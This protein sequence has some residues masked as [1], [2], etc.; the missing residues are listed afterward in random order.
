[1]RIVGTIERCRFTRGF[2]SD[3]LRNVRQKRM[4]QEADIHVLNVM[5]IRAENLR[6]H[7]MEPISSVGRA[8]H[9]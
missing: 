7:K 9:R 3:S 5:A 6:Q 4:D 8:Q 1:M 2:V